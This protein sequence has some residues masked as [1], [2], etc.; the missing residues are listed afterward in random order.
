[1]LLCLPPGLVL[2]P[3]LLSPSGAS[4]PCLPSRA[5]SRTRSRSR[6][7]HT[8]PEVNQRGVPPPGGPRSFR[9]EL[10]WEPLHMWRGERAVTPAVASVLRS[11]RAAAAEVRVSPAASAG[12]TVC[13]LKPV[14]SPTSFLSQPPHAAARS[15]RREPPSSSLHLP[16]WLTSNKSDIDGSD[17]SVPDLKYPPWI[18]CC[19][20]GRAALPTESLLW[21]QPGT[22]CL[23]AGTRK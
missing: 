22:S 4:Q 12:V 7:M 8:V 6:S 1:M 13:T 9:L 15:E 2:H 10:R 21:D 18:H 19:G 14:V 11:G 3:G 16:H 20:V 23:C 17:V 5:A